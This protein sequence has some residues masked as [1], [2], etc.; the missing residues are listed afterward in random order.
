MDRLNA[1]KGSRQTGH[2]PLEDV[3]APKAKSLGPAYGRDS[4]CRLVA[5][6]G[7]EWVQIPTGLG[8]NQCSAALARGRG[9]TR[10]GWHTKALFTHCGMGC[11]RMRLAG[12]PHAAWGH[13][14]RG[15]SGRQRRGLRA[16][17]G[18]YLSGPLWNCCCAGE[19]DCLIETQL[20]EGSSRLVP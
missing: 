5:F 1:A 2:V 17:P 20:C 13:P 12:G 6:L 18:G 11:P 7:P 10:P 19:S 8:P 15:G 9:I 3:V 16:H 4:G 14:L